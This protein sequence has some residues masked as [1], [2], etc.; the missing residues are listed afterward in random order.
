[1]TRR[2]ALLA[3]VA[4]SSIAACRHQE[5]PAAV[6]TPVRVVAVGPA[7]SPGAPRYSAAILPASRV[8]L[9]FKVPGYVADVTQVNDGAGRRRALQEGDRV[10]RGQPL[11]RLR[12]ADYD[13]K[14][15]AARS[16]QAEVEAAM[17][18][19]KQ[20]FER[21]KAL[22]ERK[23]LTRTDYDAARAAYETVL[24]R[25]SGVA[26]LAAEA[27]NAR[28]DS[29][30]RSPMDG[31]VL[32]RLVEVGSLVGP[33]TPGFVIADISAV[34]ILFG[35]PDVVVRRLALQQVVTVTT[36]AYPNDRFAGR[37]TSLAPAASPGSLVFDV[38]VTVPNKDG[39]LKPGM[40][41]SFELTAEPT[42]GVLSVPLAAIVRS[43]TR[44]DGYALF[45]VED[46]KGAPVARLREVTLGDMVATGVTVTS[47]LRA[48]DRVVISGATIVADGEAV[49]ILR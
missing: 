12:S 20:A 40:V 38:E 39:R 35:A 8:D 16:Q 34:K 29:S 19:A 23:S 15:D 10:T 48:G 44:P 31:V 7:G 26:A 43:R 32:K 33:G 47:G 27:Q 4:A 13:V 11:A 3:L 45:I 46:Q 22:Y 37:V 24:A 2:I 14:V 6:P 17:T 1:M 49:E 25:Q 5:K 41:A 21:A 18:Q 30:L 36:A 42:A 28:G 9:A